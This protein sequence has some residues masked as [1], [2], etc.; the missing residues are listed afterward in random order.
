MKIKVEISSSTLFLENGT[1]H[2]LILF[3]PNPVTLEGRKTGDDAATNPSQVL[4]LR[5]GADADRFDFGIWRGQ[6]VQL[7]KN[8][9]AESRT[10]SQ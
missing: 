4:S 7:R 3:F 5:V 2:G 9:A 1:A 6:S 10:P 8:A